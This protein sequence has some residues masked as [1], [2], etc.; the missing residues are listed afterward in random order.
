MLMDVSDSML[1]SPT[2][3]LRKLAQEKDIGLATAHEAVQEN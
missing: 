3:Q 1:Q 2:K